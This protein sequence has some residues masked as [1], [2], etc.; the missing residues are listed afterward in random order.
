MNKSIKY[1][2]KEGLANNAWGFLTIL[3]IILLSALLNTPGSF[4][5]QI[6]EAPLAMVKLGYVSYI[7]VSTLATFAITC[8]VFMP[9]VNS[10]T[11]MYNRFETLVRL[12]NS[13]KNFIFSEI[14]LEIA[15]AL[16]AF[17]CLLIA[18]FVAVGD[19]SK[20]NHNL[21]EFF[22]GIPYVEMALYYILWLSYAR[23]FAALNY[24]F[25]GKFW[26]ALGGFFILTNIL[27]FQFITGIRIFGDFILSMPKGNY[28][29]II[30]Q[31]VV[32]LAISC[33]SIMTQDLKG[34]K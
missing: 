14:L 9:W 25:G 12:Q 26:I 5:L 21:S 23:F 19:L 24:R 34:N 28:I 2:L 1:D 8:L 33:Y 10:Y 6:T 7:I 4:G 3:F 27:L 15:N 29:L 32:L 16:I 11:G 18:L 20:F 30:L 22:K 17:I 31:I 13:R